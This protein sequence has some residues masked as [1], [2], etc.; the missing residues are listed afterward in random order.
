MHLKTL[1]ETRLALIDAWKRTDTWEGIDRPIFITGL[2]R[3]G[4]TFLHE[5][6]S[7]DP[8]SRAPRLWEIMF[9]LAAVSV[10]PAEARRAIQ[11]AAFCLWWFRRIASQADSICPIRAN[12]PHECVGIHSYTLLSQEFVIMFRVPSYKAFLT[13]VDLAP[14]YE[15][16]KQFLQHLQTRGAS[17]RWVLKSPDHVFSLETLFR[18]FPEALIIQT[19]RDPLQVLRSCIRM[20]DGLQ[21][22]FAR[23][24]AIEKISAREAQALAEAAESISQFRDAHPELAGRFF[25]VYYQDLASN[26]LATIQRLYHQLNLPLTFPTLQRVRNLACHR[27]RYRQRSHVTLRQLGLD[28]QAEKRRFKGYCLRF[29]IQHS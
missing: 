17:K 16:E 11:K 26:P 22:T 6:L 1:L 5:L 15:W 20:T 23:P 29:G 10:K 4:S 12:A 3:S 19:H 14:A 8:K 25:D 21:R 18:A 28:V 13:A 9:P 24:Q 27:G 7:Q 2:P